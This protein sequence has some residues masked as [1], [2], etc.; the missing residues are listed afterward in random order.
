MHDKIQADLKAAMLAR[1]SV[2]VDTLKMLKTA[3]QMATIE[4]KGD[5][6]EDAAMAVLKKESKRRGDAATM[7]RDAGDEERASKEESEKKLIDAYL[8][9]QMSEDAI[10]AI[11]DEVI[12]GLDSPN[13]GAVMGQV[14]ARTKGQADGGVVSK[15]VKQQLG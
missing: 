1:D 14:M 11:V 12:A 10:L 5:L 2:T 15:L 9:E 8:P 6:G 7:Y 3:L 13:M 4:A